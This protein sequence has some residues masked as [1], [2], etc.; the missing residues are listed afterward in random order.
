MYLTIYLSTYAFLEIHIDQR[1]HSRLTSAISVKIK[2]KMTSHFTSMCTDAIVSV[3]Q[4]LSIKELALAHAINKQFQIITDD[5]LAWQ[6]TT[7]VAELYNNYLTISPRVHAI[8]HCAELI[9]FADH[10][11]VS[12]STESWLN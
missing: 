9:I 10:G 4:F 3:L 11:V 1:S 6:Y 7:V 12:Q 8:R 2:Y 5:P